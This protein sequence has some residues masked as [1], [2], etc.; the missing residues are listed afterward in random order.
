MLGNHPVTALVPV[1]DLDRAG[2]F[3][4][5]VLGLRETDSVEDES[6]GYECGGGTRLELFRTRAGVAAGHTECGW[7]VDDIDRVVADLRAAGVTF[8]EYDLGEGVTTEDG[9]ARFANE[10]AAWFKDPDGNVLAVFQ[11]LGS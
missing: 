7:R 4:G 5:E 8:E 11:A 3:Y 6:R 10:R 2:K 1:T 9:I